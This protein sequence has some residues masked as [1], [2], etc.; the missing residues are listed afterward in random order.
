MTYQ[1]LARKWRPQ[2]FS[3]LVG[4]E[5]VSRALTNALSLQRLHH[6]YLFTGT[7][8]VGKT[9]VARIF[10]KALNCEKGVSAEPCGACKACQAVAQGCFVD[11]IEVDA[12]SRTKVEDT[13][14]LLD[15]VQYMPTQGRYKVYLIDEVHM[16]SGHSFNA[17]LK[18]LEEPP[19]HVIFLLATTDPQRLPPTILSRCLQFHLKNLSPEYIQ[20]HLQ[21]VLTEEAIAFESAALWPLAKA[22]NGSMRDALS[23]L[24]QAISYGHEKIQLH[25]IQ[26]MLGMIDQAD[27]FRLLEGLIQH[28]A[29]ALMTHVQH[30]ALCNRDYGVL[31]E[32]LISALHQLTVIQCVPDAVQK[33]PENEMLFE[34]AEQISAETL[35]LFYQIALYGRKDLPLAP[36]ARQGLEMTLLRMLTFIPVDAA[37]KTKTTPVTS[38]PVTKSVSNVSQPMSKPS[39]EPS[40]N[41]TALTHKITAENWSSVIKMLNLSG[42]SAVLATHCEVVEINQNQ[43]ILGLSP[44]QGPLLNEQTQ[45]SFEEAIT[46]YLGRPCRVTIKLVEPRGETP[47]QHQQRENEQRYNQV[48][49]SLKVDDNIRVLTNTLGL[50]LDESSVKLID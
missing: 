30:I 27:V 28:D 45:K 23:L 43:L 44:R 15:N 26:D 36:Q 2:T 38:V 29:N 22:A 6:A 1:V 46:H 3:T 12:A 24:D 42:V 20:N 10:A 47:I 18:T 7:R 16:L 37:P 9:T 17:L 5:H 49:A 34:Y 11:L 32:E 35:Q 50:S 40:A 41:D 48:L 13:R 39:V 31:L 33:T 8:G 4:Q 19:A 14:E 25:D 21:M